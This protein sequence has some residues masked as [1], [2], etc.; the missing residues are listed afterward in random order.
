MRG[1][2][3]DSVSCCVTFSREASVYKGK[4]QEVREFRH[5]IVRLMSLCHGSALEEISGTGDRDDNRLDTIDTLGLDDK[6]LRHLKECRYEH[7]FNRVEVLLHLI[8]SLITD[9]QINGVLLVAP[10]IL[11]RV[12]QTL[13]RGFVNLLNAKK[14]ADTRFPF[15]YAQTI[16]TLLYAN[17]VLTPVLVVNLVQ[18]PIWSPLFVAV[19]LFGAFSMNFV[20]M[21]LENPF[22]DD[23]NDLPLQHFQ[24]E[25]NGCL[26]MLLQ[27]NADLVPSI[28]KTRCKTSY[29]ELLALMEEEEGSTRP[30]LLRH[31]SK[32]Q[33]FENFVYPSDASKSQSLA[34]SNGNN[35][36]SSKDKHAPRP[37]TIVDENKGVLP[38]ATVAVENQCLVPTE[39][40]GVTTFQPP[41]LPVAA[42]EERMTLARVDAAYNTLRAILEEAV[43]V[44]L[45]QTLE[46]L[47]L[48]GESIAALLAALRGEEGAVEDLPSLASRAGDR[49]PGTLTFSPSAG[50][51]RPRPQSRQPSKSSGGVITDIHLSQGSS[52][53]PPSVVS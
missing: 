2:W 27:E 10:P 1:E 43:I 53:N 36:D 25:M 11:S 24:D 23:D 28:S 6:T 33:N 12:Y 21:D 49:G 34:G 9:A 20:G 26:M 37:E 47:S 45:R 42:T 46:S 22:G 4:H 39:N 19:P 38:I 16:S 15:P 50:S 35:C 7:N 5:T 14:I 30:G 40:P 31:A 18:S 41:S 29:P 13:S 3:F 51:G 8:Q 17:L 48:L 44:D 32:S 52:L